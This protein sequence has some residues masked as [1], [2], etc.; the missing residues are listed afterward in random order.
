[1]IFFFFVNLHANVG[2]CLDWSV[3]AKKLNIKKDVVL[4]FSFSFLFSI[5]PSFK[6]VV[7]RCRLF[8]DFF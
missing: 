5:L 4:F 1:M 6:S 8:E 7:Y 2:H 3:D